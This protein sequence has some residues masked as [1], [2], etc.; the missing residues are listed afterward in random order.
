[1]VCLFLFQ[2]LPDILCQK[3]YYFA[4]KW[5]FIEIRNGQ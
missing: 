2:F 3:G 1:M 5:F 4:E